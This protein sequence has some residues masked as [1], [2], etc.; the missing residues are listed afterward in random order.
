MTRYFTNEFMS[1]DDFLNITS[2][3]ALLDNTLDGKVITLYSF[4]RIK[5]EAV[6]QH[7]LEL[8]EK[9]L[10]VIC[11][12]KGLKAKKQLKDY[13]IISDLKG[14]QVFTNNNEILKRELPLLL[15]DLTT[16]LEII[17]GDVYEDDLD[18]K[19]LY[20]DGGR[21]KNAKSGNVEKA[22]NECCL[23]V[24][25]S[26]PIINN[27]MVNRAEI[28]TA[29]TKKARL[30]IVQAILSHTDTPEF[31]RGSNQ[32][33][34]IYRSLF[35]VTGIVDGDIREDIQLVIDEI[36]RYIDSCCDK[37]VSVKGM[38]YKLVKAPYGMRAGVIPF[39]LAY[40]LANRREDIIVY[41]S[42]KEV[43]ITSDIVVNMCEQPE[44]YAVYVSKEDL[45]KEK[46][47]SELNMLFEVDDNWNLSSNRIKDIIICM[48]RWFRSLQ[49]ATRNVIYLDQYVDNDNMVQAMKTMK[50]AMQKVEFNPFE[51][52]F[53]EFP[54][55]FGTESLEET[56]NVIDDCKTRYDDY[57]RWIEEQAIKAIYDL[58]DKKRKQNLYHTLKEWYDKQGKRSKMGLYDGRMT[59]FMSCLE[60]MDVY[61]D[62]DVAS[63]VVKAVTDVYME[64]WNTGSLEEFVEALTSVKNEVE[65][66]R[67]DSVSGELELKFIGRNGE[68]IKK[69]YSY[70][71]E[72]TG[73]I[74]RNVIEDTLDE[75]DDLSVNDRVSIL[76]EMIEKII[77]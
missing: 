65:S 9:R 24:Y 54:E 55:A 41:F 52:L 22:V 2:S 70:A 67:D 60:G 63:K 47:I 51:I 34:T 14:N 49:Q 39:Y 43:Q 76:L 48:Q 10:V 29:Q 23:N 26:T 27:E 61:S 53:V 66:I 32:E 57:F 72:N 69:L 62:Q 35:C 37:K 30:N 8:A 45:Q 68:T 20:F 64:N 17:I 50:K 71:D 13:E 40:V 56:F 18:T 25:T 73:S 3:T 77:K 58:W 1:V 36:N 4:S 19:V 42:N 31:Y 38:V 5:Q 74:L 28:G 75:Y 44:D 7:L 16:E 11:P 46:Y 21:I 6:K 33:A 59:N 12:K 15:D